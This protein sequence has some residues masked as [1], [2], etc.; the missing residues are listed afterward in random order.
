MAILR[1]LERT[2][3]N[4]RAA[5]TILGVYRPTLYSKLK[6]YNLLKRPAPVGA[7]N[8][9]TAGIVGHTWNDRLGIR[10]APATPSSGM[11]RT[12]CAPR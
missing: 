4:K 5:A 11:S 8:Q 9:L 3:W 7:P 10:I 12:T 6:K 2:Q 1:T